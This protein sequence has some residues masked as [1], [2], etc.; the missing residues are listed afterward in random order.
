MLV[1]IVARIGGLVS[2]PFGLAASFLIHR[3]SFVPSI[4]FEKPMLDV[5]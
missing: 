1:R 3:L 4:V 5:R 2:R